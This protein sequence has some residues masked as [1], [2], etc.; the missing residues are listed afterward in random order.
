MILFGLIFAGFGL[1]FMFVLGNQALDEVKTY[2]WEEIPCEIVLC[3]ID[4]DSSRDKNPFQLKVRYKYSINGQTRFS[5]RYALQEYWSDDYE[6]LALQ[7]KALLHDPLTV[8]YVDFDGSSSAILKRDGLITSLMVL[9]PLI[10]VLIGGGIVWGGIISLKKKKRLEAGGTESISKGGAKSK[11]TGWK[12]MIILGSIFALVGGGVAIPLGII[13]ITKM[14]ESKSWQETPCKILW[15]KVRRH[16][17]TSDGKTSITWSV[18]IFY[19]YEVGGVKHRSNNY[20]VFGGSSSGRGSKVAITKQ[21]RR[22]SQQICYVDPKVPERALLKRGFSWTMLFAL[23]PL[24]FFVVGVAILRSGLKARGKVKTASPEGGRFA[25]AYRASPS[26]SAVP[27][28][29]SRRSVFSSRTTSDTVSGEARELSP[30]KKR[31][32]GAGVVLLFALFW[33]GIVS[34]FLWQVVEGFQKGR[35]EWFM[36]LFLIPFVLI[37]VVLILV[38]FY[39]L[40]ALSNP[41]PVITLTPGVLRPGQSFEVSWKILSNSMRIKHM[42]IA[43]WGVES[44]TYRRGTKSHTSREVFYVHTLFETTMNSDMRSGLVKFEMPVDAMPSLNTGNNA[45]EWELRV[46]GDIP[47]WPD[48][49]DTYK[50]EVS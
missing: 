25:D 36:V 6:K 32:G 33:N 26:E 29:D 11:N 37:G 49:Q 30:G 16:E 28:R 1:V 27:S 5:N 39:Q 13:P 18:D 41:K 10:F 43:L 40:L 9:F 47:R 23:I 20:R 21:Y 31:L 38:F 14:V 44:A 46:N 24:V 8:C 45:I 42:K 50:I 35:A 4:A 19:E 48:V 15:S 22:G 17:S 3:E 34:I 12:V 2:Q 7:R